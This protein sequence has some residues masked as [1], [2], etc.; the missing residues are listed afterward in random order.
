MYRHQILAS[1]ILWTHTCGELNLCMMM[2]TNN[3]ET[4][5]P[6]HR[7][8]PSSWHRMAVHV[9]I[10]ILV[11]VRVQRVCG[12]VRV[13]QFSVVESTQRYMYHTLQCGLDNSYKYIV[14]L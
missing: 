4:A 3:P 12:D 9:H 1:D 6:I 2:K 7:L 8:F 13:I 10:L 11:H 14:L 5:L